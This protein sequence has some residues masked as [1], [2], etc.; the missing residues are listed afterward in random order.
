MMDEWNALVDEYIASGKDRRSRFDIERLSKIGAH[1][2]PLYREC[3]AD[4]CKL[5]EVRDVETL[6]KCS[7]CKIVSACHRFALSIRGKELTDVVH[8]YRP[9]TAAPHV[10]RRIGRLT[11]K[12]VARRRKE[13]SSCP[14]RG[15]RSCSSRCCLL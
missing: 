5:Y 7:G 8:V 12:S 10:K 6:R 9:F 2:G 4:E 15:R 1:G 13:H 14:C 11:R 3:E